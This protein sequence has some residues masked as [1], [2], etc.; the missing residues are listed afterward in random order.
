MDMYYMFVRIAAR[1]T[2][3]SISC[4]A[5]YAL[6]RCATTV[7]HYYCTT[8]L[9]CLFFYLPHIEAAMV[10]RHT[11]SETQ[12]HMHMH[13][14]WAY[15]KKHMNMHIH[16]CP[17]PWFQQCICFLQ[18]RTC[19]ILQSSH[20]TER[21]CYIHVQCMYSIQLYVHVHCIHQIS[22][23]LSWIITS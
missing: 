14:Q 1:D 16:R 17:I 4:N 19:H 20:R 18:W 11:R 9:Q 15:C 12:I 6:N 2:C 21:K 23:I 13:M 10:F 22:R 8:V 3:T 5:Q 7:L